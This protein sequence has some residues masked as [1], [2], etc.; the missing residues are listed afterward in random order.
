[1]PHL[2]TSQRELRSV[3]SLPGDLPQAY[4][5]AAVRVET[6]TIRTFVLDGEIQAAPGQFVMAW[7]PRLDEKP[8]SLSGAAP[9]ALTVDRVGPFS[10]AM[11]ALAPGDRLWL[12]GP[13]GR[14]FGIP[15]GSIV[16]TGPLLL[17][18]G[19]C[20]V[21]PLLYLAQVAREAGHD[22]H[23]VL[24][25]R[26]AA[27]LLLEEQFAALGC[28]VHLAT[29][30][31]SA[32]A[33]GT[34]LDLAASLVDAQVVSPASLYA[35]G[36]EPMLEGVYRLAQAHSLPCQLSYEAYMRCALGVCGSCVR[37]DRLVC[38]D[39]PV[40]EQPPNNLTIQPPNDLSL[41]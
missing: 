24:G 17:I 40:F 30:D 6:P 21:A 16:G 35:C 12:R 9:F 29:D 13:Y 10:T 8:F 23:A 37:G 14:G 27:G 2:T 38:R 36:P 22:V 34:S 25:A 26:T 3:G 18:S 31:G 1:M 15:D 32:G 28:A 5:I 4:T 19:G 39:G 11:H 7:L 41:A 33:K 20:G